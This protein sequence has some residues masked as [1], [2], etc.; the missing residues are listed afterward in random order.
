[1]TELERKAHI[2]ALQLLEFNKLSQVDL[3]VVYF[4][5][6]NWKMED[7]PNRTKNF[8]TIQEVDASIRVENSIKKMMYIQPETIIS[9]VPEDVDQLIKEIPTYPKS[10]I[11]EMLEIIFAEEYPKWEFDLRSTTPTKF[12]DATSNI[13]VYNEFEVELIHEYT[14]R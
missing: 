4:W 7:W 10:D 2:D 14:R 13:F 11:K 8:I 5:Y 1:L 6:Q 3:G 12:V 9:N